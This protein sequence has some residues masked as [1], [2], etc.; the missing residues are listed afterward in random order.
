MMKNLLEKVNETVLELW[1][2]ILLWGIVCQLIPVWFLKE[3]ADYS[4]GLWLGILLAGASAFHM[5]WALDRGLDRGGAAQGYIRKTAFIRYAVIV[6]VFAVVMLTRAANPLA[7]FLGIMGLKAA[8]YLQPFVHR[9]LH[10]DKEGGR[11][12]RLCFRIPLNGTGTPTERT[13][14]KIWKRRR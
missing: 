2:G 1:T 9:R 13:V 3:K 5:W 6:V 7:V 10:P 8:A 12:R 14:P 4:L 11:G